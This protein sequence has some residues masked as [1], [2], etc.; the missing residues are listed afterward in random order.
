LPGP[1][2]AFA[3]RIA[4]AL[5]ASVLGATIVIAAPGVLS[6]KS[7]ADAAAAEF[8]GGEVE[9]LGGPLLGDDGVAPFILS[10]RNIVERQRALA[11]LS[12]AIYFEA[13]HEPVEGRRAVA[14]VVLNRARDPHFPA[15][16]CGVVYQG[17]ELGV[18]QFSFVCDGSL[19]RRPPSDVQWTDAWTVAADALTGRVERGIGTATHYHATYIAEPWGDTV[20]R[21]GVIGQH[22][23]YRWRGKAGRAAALTSIYAGEGRLPAPALSALAAYLPPGSV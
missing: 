13:A 21:T 7:A 15:S 11:C 2:A 22:V 17:V 14:Q 3:S 8:A 1:V 5:T 20:V 19:V 18:C 12:Q 4:R 6:L 16:V 10:P 9:L 23:F